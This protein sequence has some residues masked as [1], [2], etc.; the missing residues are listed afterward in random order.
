MTTHR[1][2]LRWAAVGVP[3]LLAAVL[4][5]L[6]GQLTPSTAALVLVLAVVG[7][8]ATG[9]RAAGVASAVS[10]AV[11]FDFFLTVPYYSLSIYDR[12]NV[13]VAVVLVVVG[14]AVTELALWGHRQQVAARMRSGYIDGVLGLSDVIAT[15]SDAALPKTIG[16]AMKTVLGV[17]RVA[18]TAGEPSP[19]APVVGRDGVV[20]TDGRDLRVD[21]RGLPT[22]LVTVIPVSRGEHVI[23]HFTLVAAT[24]VVRPGRDQLRAAILLAE[25]MTRQERSTGTASG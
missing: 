18:W 1:G 7:V 13:E 14:L 10:A 12:D 9:D 22:D 4:A 25:Q 8:S 17:D 20:R 3:I 6:R 2:V 11:A 15:G 19:N 23:G 5:L 21:R 16:A 24:R